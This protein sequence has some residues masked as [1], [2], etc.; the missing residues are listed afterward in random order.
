MLEFW[1]NVDVAILFS[2]HEGLFISMIESMAAGCVQMVTNV[3][4]VSDSVEHGISGF[5]YEIGDITAMANH[6]FLLHQDSE[7]LSK[8]FE[9]C[10][11]NVKQHH[12]PDDYDTVLLRLCRE[13]GSNH[14]D[15]GL[16]FKV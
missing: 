2:S 8:M 3:S 11:S 1:S 16:A 6:L 7:L 5:I 13:H 9:A 4:G 12:D 15:A 14:S 10:I